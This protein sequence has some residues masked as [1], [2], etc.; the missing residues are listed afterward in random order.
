MSRFRELPNKREDGFA[1]LSVI[2]LMT[3]VTLFAVTLLG[4]VLAQTAPTLL[5]NKSSR[6]QSA[7]QAGLDAAI[8]QLRNA[9]SI[10]G[11]GLSMGDIHKLPC[12]VTGTVDGTG[13]SA[14]YSASVQYFVADPKGK[15][16]AWRNTN[17]L[18]C[19]TGTGTNGGVRSVPHFAMIN[20]EG[21]D[22]TA[23]VVVNRADRVLEA[24][25]TFQLTTQKV[26]GG[27][28][29]DAG[30]AYCLVATGVRR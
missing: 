13:G 10:D 21:F 15:D 19:Y 29:L 22:D 4:L 30:N 9:E 23:V 24:T 12:T 2:L 17:A 7:A 3:M 16:T 6:T 28:I 1:L 18:N 5:T 25:Y 27:M 14:H 20:S 8:G 11:T 26:S